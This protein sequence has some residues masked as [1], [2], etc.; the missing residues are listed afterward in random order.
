MEQIGGTLSAT[1]KAMASNVQR[2]MQMAASMN[3]MMEQYL[4]RSVDINTFVQG[5]Q[6]DGSEISVQITLNNQSHLPIPGCTL[7]L[8]LASPEDQK[9]IPFEM[10]CES[11]P[12]LN[13]IP[14]NKVELKKR[15]PN[16]LQ[17]GFTLAPG[18]LQ[19]TVTLEVKQMR[20]CNG[21]IEISFP[22]IGTRRMLSVQHIFGV[23]LI[24]RCQRTWVKQHQEKIGLS[25]AV[26]F[27]GGFLRSFFKVPHEDGIVPGSAFKLSVAGH[28]ILLAVKSVNGPDVW[29]LVHM[30]GARFPKEEIVEEILL[31]MDMYSRGFIKLYNPI[32]A[33]PKEQ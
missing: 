33:M 13:L 8:S 18:K 14:E 26:S 29:V 22:S 10:E 25:V 17:K 5:F 19:W 2:S 9:S 3:A 32:G 20:P 23:Y 21:K 31:E 4:C 16:V 15:D 24:H 7:S 12:S 28:T 11:R 27:D 30:L 1:Y 6:S